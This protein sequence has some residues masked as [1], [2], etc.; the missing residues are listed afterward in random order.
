MSKNVFFRVLITI[1]FR[2]LVSFLVIKIYKILTVVQTNTCIMLL[3]RLYNIYN[4]T[5][6]V[7]MLLF[8]NYVIR[9]VN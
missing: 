6:T 4:I 9:I 2:F 3:L 8:V 5:Q 1:L 7:K